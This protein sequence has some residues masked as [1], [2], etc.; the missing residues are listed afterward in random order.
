MSGVYVWTNKK[1]QPHELFM[2]RPI[3]R[4]CF[5]MLG[6]LSNPDLFRKMRGN[7]WRYYEL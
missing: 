4:Q 1:P 5:Y 2:P 7:A 3:S 6:G